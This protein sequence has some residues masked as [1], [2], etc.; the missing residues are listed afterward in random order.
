MI[1]DNAVANAQPSPVPR[2]LGL[3]VKKSRY[4]IYYVWRYACAVVTEYYF[5]IGCVVNGCRFSDTSRILSTCDAGYFSHRAY[6]ALLIRF[7]N[8]LNLLGMR[9]YCRQG[10]RKIQLY[11]NPRFL[12]CAPTRPSVLC[13]IS[14]I[15]ANTFVS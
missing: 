8:L 15:R 7:K 9:K 5:Y 6:C 14:P 4:F 11:G 1:A 12:N 2:F 10:I 13:V 3:V